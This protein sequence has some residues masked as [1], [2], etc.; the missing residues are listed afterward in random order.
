MND[1]TDGFKTASVSSY[2][3]NEKSK[4]RVIYIIDS[5]NNEYFIR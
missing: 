3:V 1:V 5:S 2:K 4:Y